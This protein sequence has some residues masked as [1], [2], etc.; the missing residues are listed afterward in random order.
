MAKARSDLAKAR[1]A[2]RPSPIPIEPPLAL[3][4][5]F[6]AVAAVLAVI[7]WLGWFSPE[8]YDTDFW[9]HLKTGQF[10]V[11]N[12]ALPVPDPFAFTTAGAGEAYPGEAIAR[13]F[14]LTHE[15]LAQVLLYS[16]W[17][18]AGFGGVVLFRAALLAG[19]CSLVGLI[20]WR[21]CGGFY[22]SLAAACAT[23]GMAIRFALDRPYLITFLLLAAAIAILE[24][25]RW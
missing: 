6:P 13:Y 22:R 16:V 18:A 25:R 2:R 12:R 19:L 17:R 7:L 11:Q 15:W 21:R 9:W 10:I 1:S 23:A 20:A 4:R 8:I 24:Y 14:N 5:W 3:S